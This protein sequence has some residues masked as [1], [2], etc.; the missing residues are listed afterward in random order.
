MLNSY[1]RKEDICTHLGDDYE[2]YLGAIVPPI[3]QN[4]LFTQ[5]TSDQGYSYTRES[6]PTIEIAEKKIAALEEGEAAKCF[7]S[8][9]AAVSA[10][11]M[12]WL[13]KDDH[14]ICIKSVYP[15]ARELLDSYLRKFG[16]EITYV[17]GAAV[18]EFEQAIQPNTKLIYLESPSSLIFAMQDLAAVAKLAQAYGIATVID[19]TWATPL[20]QNPLNFGIDMVI[21]SATKYLGGHSDILGGAIVSRAE[22]L[23]ELNFRERGLFGAV[24]DPHQAWLLI[25]SLRTLPV[26]MLQHQQSSLAMATFLERHEAV[27]QVFYP[28]LPSHPQYELG[29]KQM[30]GYSGVMGFIVNR[31]YE[32]IME[33]LRGLKLYEIGPSWGGFESLI[34]PMKVDEQLAWHLGIPQG[35][36]LVRISVGLEHIDSL[37]GDLEQGLNGL[38]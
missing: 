37:I 2:R 7:S 12:H 30:S 14:I 35:A 25:R 28:G 11:V 21:H 36:G 3:F 38:V 6:N 17:S 23:E 32:Q 34:G 1:S 10:A 33:A 26:R 20:F 19:N 24:M 8:G 29:Q 9:M 22:V 18:E 16:I 31:S 27:S 13:S 4:T 5:K 15:R